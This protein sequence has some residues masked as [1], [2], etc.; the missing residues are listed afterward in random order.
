[1]TSFLLHA[2]RRVEAHVLALVFAVSR[3]STAWSSLASFQALAMRLAARV[4]FPGTGW[5][6]LLELIDLTGLKRFLFG[7]RIFPNG[8]LN[9]L[10]F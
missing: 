6:A 4:L 5:V 7:K 9:F 1:M 10:D 8:S 2:F 3:V